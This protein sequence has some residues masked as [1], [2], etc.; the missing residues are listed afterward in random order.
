[1]T[2]PTNA[3]TP[4]KPS[5]L[6]SVLA[7]IV[8]WGLNFVVMKVGLASFTPFQLGAARFGLAFL[9]LAFWVGLPQVRPRWILAF[10][11]TQGVGQ[12]GLLFV[13]LRVGMTAA[14]ASVVMQTQVFFTAI[15]GAML[16]RERIGGPLRVGFAFAAAG[17]ACFAANVWTAHGT[18]VTGW[19]LALNLGS[20]FMWACS[21]IVVRKAQQDSGAFQPLPFVVWASAVAIVP[22][23]LLS[24]CFDPP[25]SQGNWRHA[26]WQAW[27]AVAALGWLATSLAYGLWTGLLKRFAASR[28]APFSLG[29]PVIGMLA[30]IAFLGET[31]APLQWAGVFLV[32]CALC[33]VLLAQRLPPASSRP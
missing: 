25:G 8:I 2:T 22:F 27:A 13:A 18:A 29:V 9:P 16:L 31:I 17:L 12:F 3:Q 15:L 14:V 23:L 33:C 32:F 19:G 26:P 10:G 1:M 6:A 21:N 20:A 30:G 4:F 11:L 24:W 7:V 28:V 5:D